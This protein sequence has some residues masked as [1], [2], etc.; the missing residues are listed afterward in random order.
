M[1]TNGTFIISLDFELHWGVFERVNYDSPYM[2]NLFQ[3]PQAI[4][5]ILEL[6]E[7]RNISATWAI[8]GFLFADSD[9]ML[10]EFEPEIKPLYPCPGKNPYL[11]KTGHNEYDD[12]IHF[13]PSKIRRIQSV[14][15]QEIATHTFSHFLC[16][17]DGAT[18][19]AFRSDLESS[20]RIADT[21]GIKLNTI[22]FPKN[23]IIN[24]FLDV[25]PEK[26]I[27][28]YRETEKGWMYSSSRYP[29]R[30]ITER[31]SRSLKKS[32]R[33]LDAYIPLSG[34]NTWSINELSSESGKPTGIPASFFLRLFDPRL[35]IFDWL[36]LQR[37]KN[38]IEHAA[39]FNKMVHLRCHPHNFG[40]NPVEN[41]RFLEKI[42]DHFQYCRSE[43]G[44]KSMNMYEFYKF[45]DKHSMA[46]Y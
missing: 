25:L 34:T 31:I 12:P 5:M 41:I 38:Q 43:Y 36:K 40:S 13:A 29:E 9:Q 11:I 1:L 39:K 26:G 8:I 2:K 20:V 14:A 23:Q 19:E 42:L 24:K 46:D 32:A 18:V 17:S 33:L 6:F 30:S 44:M 37:I 21:F 35:I 45:L 10:K 28:V 15:G 27:N 7:K 4:D 3:T 16:N 22:V